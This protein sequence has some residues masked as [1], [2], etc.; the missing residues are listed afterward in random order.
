[1]SLTRCSDALKTWGSTPGAAPG[2]A[3][4]QIVLRQDDFMRALKYVGSGAIHSD[5]YGVMSC[6]I[7]AGSV[8]VRCWNAD[9]PMAP[10]NA[11]TLPATVQ[12]L[13]SAST[14]GYFK[15]DGP[16]V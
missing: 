12:D 4:A 16:H 6:N 1:M 14:A 9:H 3:P 11:F 13:S 2:T 7:E 10:G 5:G 8:T 15:F